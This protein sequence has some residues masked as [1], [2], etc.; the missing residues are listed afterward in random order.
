MTVGPHNFSVLP[1]SRLTDAEN[2]LSSNGQRIANSLALNDYFEPPTS[3]ITARDYLKFEF[4]LL[5]KG[6]QHTLVDWND[7]PNLDSEIA[8]MQSSRQRLQDKD[9]FV[10]EGAQNQVLLEL[11]SVCDLHHLELV[12]LGTPLHQNYLNLVE[13]EGWASYRDRLHYLDSIHTNVTYLAFEELNWPD[14]LFKD[15]SHVNSKGGRTLGKM[16]EDLQK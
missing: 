2:W 3:T 14:S 16:L 10:T 9:W 4:L 1:E 7:K 8:S 5:N 15:V 12:L 11:I 6:I 13:A